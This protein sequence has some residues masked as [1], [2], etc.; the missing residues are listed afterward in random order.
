MK[1]KQSD[2]FERNGWILLLAL[3][4]FVFFHSK[5]ILWPLVI[6]FFLS[7]LIGSAVWQANTVIQDPNLRKEAIIILS[8]RGLSLLLPLLILGIMGL[9]NGK[10]MSELF[11]FRHPHD[12]LPWITNLV[13]FLGAAYHLSWLWV[14]N[15]PESLEKIEKILDAVPSNQTSPV[16]LLLRKIFCS[17]YIIF[18]LVMN[19]YIQFLP[20]F[21]RELLVD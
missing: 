11:I 19:W 3:L 18:C 13:F 21:P 14:G 1:K 17:L 5:M 15:G 8:V 4:L 9:L 10:N 16:N 2:V 7:V 12:A 6:A 20:S